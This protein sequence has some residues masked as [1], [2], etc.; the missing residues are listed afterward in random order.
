M[1][2]TY[3][4]KELPFSVPIN[5]ADIP[6]EYLAILPPL[7]DDRRYRWLLTIDGETGALIWAYDY[8]RD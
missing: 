8:Y 6:D 4:G 7:P 2:V 1:K 5:A 3:K